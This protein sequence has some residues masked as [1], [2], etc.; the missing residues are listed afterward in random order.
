VKWSIWAGRPRW[1]NES[2]ISGQTKKRSGVAVLE[3]YQG[4]AHGRAPVCEFRGVVFPRGIESSQSG[5]RGG[6][7]ETFKAATRGPRS[8]VSQRKDPEWSV[9]PVVEV[10][11]RRAI[12]ARPSIII[13]ATR[14]G[15]GTERLFP[16]GQAGI[17]RGLSAAVSRSTASDEGEVKRKP[18]LLG[19]EGSQSDNLK[20]GKN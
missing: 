12:E 3:I 6:A 2:P 4:S 18:P 1:E 10:R 13:G 7:M 9:R 17:G 5:A 14:R 20:L 11:M 16:E 15:S 19:C 8:L